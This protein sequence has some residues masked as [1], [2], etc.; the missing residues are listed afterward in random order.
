ML[1]VEQNAEMALQLAD[2]V[3]VIDNT[4]VKEAQGIFR[5]MRIQS[6]IL[7]AVASVLFVS[8][9]TIA[10]LA[11]YLSRSANEGAEAPA[12]CR[13][14]WRLSPSTG[15]VATAGGG[16]GWDRSS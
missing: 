1:L 11:A 9:G 8:M 12:R 5:P 4:A 3:Y 16:C 2:R 7:S 6:L 13:S 14:R 15:A 10:G